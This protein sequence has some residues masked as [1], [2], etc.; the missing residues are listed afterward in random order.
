MKSILTVL[1]VFCFI[2]QAHGQLKIGVN[3]AI[4]AGDVS[5]F[6]SLSA[7]ADIYYMFGESKDALA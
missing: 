3:A 2:G 4:P 1:V 5:D 6:Y 7:G